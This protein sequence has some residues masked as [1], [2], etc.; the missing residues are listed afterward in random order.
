MPQN[1]SDESTLRA[2]IRR[3][4]RT[5][6]VEPRYEDIAMNVLAVAIGVVAGLGAVVFRVGI[7]V[8]QELLYGTS[9][10][11]GNVSFALVP[12]T[13]AFDLLS[14]LGPLRY[15]AIPALGGLL[16]G[17]VVLLTT[18]AVKGHGVPSVLDAML[19]R[20]G[21]I[22]PKIALYKTLASS[23]AIGSGASLGRE[24]P[25]IQIGSAAGSF[26]GR[27]VRSR[28]TRTL[29]AAGAAAG[30]AGT[31]NTPIGGIMFAL[32]IL[33]AEYYLGHVITVVLAALTA[34]AVARPILEFS[35]TPGIRE[36]LVPASYQ[37]VT[38]AVELPI[39]LLLGAVVGLVGAGLVKLL[40]GVEHFFERLDAPGYLKPALGGL[41][42]GVSV[43]VGTVVL[44]VAPGEA[45]G[46]L[47]GVGYGVVH[48]SI[49][50]G[51]LFGA[52]V[53][54]AV[55]K[56]VGFSLSVGSGSSG[57]VFSPSLFVG[58]TVG[59]AF[60]LAVHALVPGTAPS[61]AYALVGMGG[62]FAATAGA[63]LTAII[64]IFELTGQYTI[65][66]P[67]LMVSV[68][69]SEIASY[70]LNG[71]TIYTQKLRDLGYTVQE[72]RIGS[73]ED[74][75]VADVMTTAVDTVKVGTPLSEAVN[76]LRDTDHGG[77]P[78]VEADESLAG[79]VVQSD[80]QGYLTENIEAL[81]GDDDPAAD[82]P[83][84]EVGTRT[85][86]TTT[87]N[88][89]LLHVVD[90]MEA[91]DVGRVP[92][93]DGATVVG[94]VTRSDVLDAYD[95]IPIESAVEPMRCRRGDEGAQSE[96][97]AAPPTAAGDR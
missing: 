64:I 11:P 18:D 17:V 71:S 63:P 40:Y 88:S 23:V 55:L 46:L 66:L 94:I 1:P 2:R 13:N 52:L 53:A 24:G 22:S 97:R 14:P 79:I 65:I 48:R 74:V 29:V 20:G 77:L 93:V 8:V 9:L 96:S 60:G 21:R 76:R 61:G 95:D 84:E 70:L 80:A 87:P 62:I 85:V 37:L 91:A 16:V 41:L 56:A 5:A 51:F 81:D 57:G 34:T 10:N 49:D 45:A 69:G 27:F 25:I 36:F 78:I 83:V 43:L 15:A 75:H 35:P 59:G 82:P 68:V 12:V 54:L 92:V 47:L 4:I 50:G 89:N 32:E 72:R 44:G 39:Y 28:H 38:P 73:I 86:V 33:L 67:L 58:A 42:L 30:I 6:E 90:A 7:W 19:N 3:A 26:F 31:F